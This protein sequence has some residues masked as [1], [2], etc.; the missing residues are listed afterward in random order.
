MFVSLSS[1]DMIDGSDNG[2]DAMFMA[3][4][5]HKANYSSNSIINKPSLLWKFKTNGQI[6]SS[7]IIENGTVFVGSNNSNLYAINA[8]TGEEKWQ[9]K[10]GG[11]ISSTPAISKGNV[12]FLSQDGFFY[13][14]NEQNGTLKWKFKTGGESVYNVKDYYNGSFKPDFWD[15]YLSSAVVENNKVYFGSSDGHI[16]AIEIASGKTI[17]KYNASSSVHS[18]PAIYKGSLTVGSW[19]GTIINLK[20][21]TGALNWK[22]ETG[23]DLEYYVMMGIQ[24]SPSIENDTVYLGSRDAKFY[25]LNVST[26]DT[27]WTKS[28]FG[29]SWMPSSAAIGENSIFTG[30]SDAFKF[31]SI[32]KKTGN[33]NYTTNTNAYTFS[34]PALDQKMAYI[35]SA[36][37]RIYGIDQKSGNIQWEFKTEGNKNDTLN[38]FNARGIMDRERL[39]ELTKNYTD[40]PSL[41]TFMN[42][43]F[44]N[45]GAIMSSPIIDDQIIYFGSSDGYVYAITDN[46]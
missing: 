30:S 34:T 28:E 7:P 44:I 32:D 39:V 27:I 11:S 19:D 46:L 21:D 15:F 13:C 42:S 10:T 17:W 18:S 33:I 45:S 22:Y 3:T 29:G 37:G 16:Y 6:L 35:G 8:K 36:N 5:N 2:K 25:A 14:L 20:T 26:G 9:F 1:C 40:M 12:L 41:N 31:Y 23:K 24:A 4:K 38:I 43:Y